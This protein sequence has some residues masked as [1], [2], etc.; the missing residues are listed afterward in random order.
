MALR[1]VG[2]ETLSPGTTTPLFST[3]KPQLDGVG[4][5]M[6]LITVEGADIRWTDGDTNTPQIVLSATVGAKLGD[7]KQ[8]EYRGDFATWRC[9]A[10]SGTPTVYIYKYVEAP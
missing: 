2:K 9:I 5:N 1:P 4:M 8:M 3:A 6:W 10:V 7:G